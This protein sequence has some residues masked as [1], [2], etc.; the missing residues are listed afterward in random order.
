M[1]VISSASDT[2][3]GVMALGPAGREPK[4]PKIP[5]QPAIGTPKPKL[6]DR[7]HICW[8]VGTTFGLSRSRLAAM[9]LARRWS[10]LISSTKEAEACCITGA[11]T[12]R[13]VL[14]RP[15]QKAYGPRQSAVQVTRS[16]K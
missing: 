16:D 14:S 4:A 8:T 1:K 13:S 12:C 11:S 6:L 15:V 10:V 5:Q 9:T 3:H 2:Q 7:L